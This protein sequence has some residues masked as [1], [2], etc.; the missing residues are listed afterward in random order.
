MRPVRCELTAGRGGGYCRELA[1]F[2][3]RIKGEGFV[4]CGHGAAPRERLLNWNLVFERRWFA[5]L[6]RLLHTPALVLIPDIDSL[7]LTLPTS[8]GIVS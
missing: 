7:Q 3:D 1:R 2:C 6:I 8:V 4:H 5:N